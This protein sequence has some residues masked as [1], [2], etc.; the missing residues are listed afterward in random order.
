[1][2]SSHVGTGIALDGDDIGRPS[3]SNGADAV[4]ETADLGGGAG[5]DV[6]DVL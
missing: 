1:M 5:G 2:E 6:N 3:H 4:I